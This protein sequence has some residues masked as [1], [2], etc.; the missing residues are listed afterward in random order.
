M[1]RWTVAS[2]DAEQVG[3]LP[4]GQVGSPCGGGQQYAVVQQERPGA[5]ASALLPES[6]EVTYFPRFGWASRQASSRSTGHSGV[7]PT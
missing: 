6:G 3:K 7:R 5:P 2:P 4:L 1:T